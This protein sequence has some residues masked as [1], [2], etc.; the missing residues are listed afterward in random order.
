MK[1]IIEKLTTGVN[2][3]IKEF[4]TVVIISGILYIEIAIYKK[5]AMLNR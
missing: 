3:Y 1:K 5:K 4:I 2:D